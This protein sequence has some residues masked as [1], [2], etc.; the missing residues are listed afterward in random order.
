MSTVILDR[1]GVINFDS[2]DYIKSVEEWRP[3]PGSIEAI[4]RLSQAGIKV[5]VATNQSGLAR[6]YFSLDDLRQMHEKLNALVRKF[7]GEISG[8]FFCPH[9]PDDH[10]RCRKPNTGLLEKIAHESGESLV[11]APFVGDSLSDITA[12]KDFGCRPILVKTGK[13]LSTLTL[14]DDSKHNIEVFSN[15]ESFVDDYLIARV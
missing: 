10:C 2:D 7:G 14:V 15:L 6:N 11:G 8:I 1:D 4:G 13:G 3:I 9:H 5:Y 12:A